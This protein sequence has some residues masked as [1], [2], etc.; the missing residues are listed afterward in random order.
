MKSQ[1]FLTNDCLLRT[2]NESLTGAIPASQPRPGK[3]TAP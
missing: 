2:G 3:G 1:A